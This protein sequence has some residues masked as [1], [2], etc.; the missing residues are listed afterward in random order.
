MSVDGWT[1]AT[2]HPVTPQCMG[3]RGYPS[4]NS[5]VDWHFLLLTGT[6]VAEQPRSRLQHRDGELPCAVSRIWLRTCATTDGS[7]CL[8]PSLCITKF[9]KLLTMLTVIWSV[10]NH[11]WRSGDT[12][13]GETLS[14]SPLNPLPPFSCTTPPQRLL[15]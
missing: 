13:G 3:L 11:N 15:L 5:A 2:A 14:T 10:G 6:G 9:V 1:C 12:G 4:A 7:S 8:P